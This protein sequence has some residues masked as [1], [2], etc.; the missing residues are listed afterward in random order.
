MEQCNGRDSDYFSLD[1][2]QLFGC[3]KIA[4]FAD[5]L[6]RL[7]KTASRITITEILSELFTKTETGEIK[8][9]V[10]LLLGSLAPR[11]ETVVFNMADK[12]VARAIAK[13][14]RVDE[15]EII[16]KYKQSGDLGDT[17]F[18]C[19]SVLDTESRT[20]KHGSPIRSGMTK[21]V[22]DD[23]VVVYDQLLA[24]AQDSGEGS[25]ERKIDTLSKLLVSVDPLSAKY[26]T[27]MVLGKLR[28]G[29]SDKTVIDALSWMLA[30]DKSK[31]SVIN[32]AYEV[33]PD[34]GLLAEK[35]KKDP[36][37]TSLQKV[38]PVLG[39]PVLSMLSARLKN[40]KE[41]L[42]KMNKVAIEPK[43]DGLRLQIHFSAKGPIK[44][45]TRN[46]NE[47]GWMFPELSAIYRQLKVKEVILD[48][49]V[50][51]VDEETKKMADFQTTM[52]RRRKYG[53]EEKKHTLP[54]T[55]NVFD[56]LLVDGV[57]LMGKSYLDR[58]QKLLEIIG[59]GD[60]L[61]LVESKITTEP[62]EMLVWYKEKIALGFEGIMIKKVDSGYVPGR[63]GWRWVKM[64]DEQTSA[65]KLSDT[66]DCV[67]MGYS[68]GRGKRAT[69]GVGQFLVGVVDGELVKT[70]S[71][72]GTGLTDE[73]FKTLNTKLE[74]LAVTDKPKEYG[75]INKLHEP[76]V[77]VTPGVVVELAADDITVSPM[78]S[79]GF[80]LR[81][82]RLVKFRL[83]KSW[84]EAT[85]LK[86]ISDMSNI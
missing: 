75:L 55:F 35:V 21:R 71:K 25:V 14:Y 72:V 30:G 80:A 44:G 40:P 19:H 52:T 34:V 68:K 11:Y 83:D 48:C 69:F 43:I 4:D 57:N 23:I 50:V 18:W 33:V 26:I 7:D 79:S 54:V 3:M 42:A 46:L 81:F 86:E 61:V 2:D 77:W 6:A 85:T 66:V 70:I 32:K 8:Q 36:A 53:I 45:F 12:V 28:L 65:G 56:V 74:K 13:A 24:L 31:S 15:T 39:I 38:A 29:F 51:G 22:R 58:R 82:P 37:L 10:Y 76:D 9:M 73:E 67:V 5:Y 84:R 62:S 78:H 27:R 16:K 20:G 17:A 59:K 60:L 41:I 64:K 49:E 63:L 47:V 1:Y